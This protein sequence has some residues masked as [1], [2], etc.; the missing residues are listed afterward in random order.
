ML[1]LLQVYA[2]LRPARVLALW[3]L[4][5]ENASAVHLFRYIVRHA[6]P[7]QIYVTR[8]RPRI[9]SS[10]AKEALAAAICAAVL[11]FDFKL[12]ALGRCILQL[13]PRCYNPLHLYPSPMWGM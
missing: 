13:C 8:M 12:L 4:H 3:K 10:F 6:P 1:C 9:R 5:A 2:L 11:R 7:T